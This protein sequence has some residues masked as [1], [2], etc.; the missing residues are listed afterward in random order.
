MSMTG[1]SY[2]ASG[3]KKVIPDIKSRIESARVAM[4]DGDLEKAYGLILNTPDF[5][6][7]D[8]GFLFG[9]TL[10]GVERVDA[11]IALFDFLK[12]YNDDIL[13][14]FDQ[15]QTTSNE[16]SGVLENKENAHFIYWNAGFNNA[17]DIVKICVNKWRETL[18]DRLVELSDDNLGDYVELHDFSMKWKESNM[19]HFSDYLR[20]MLLNRYGGFWIDA[21]TY[22]GQYYIRHME[23]VS[24]SVRFFSPKRKERTLANSYLYGSRDS[25]II[26]KM[27]STLIVYMREFGRHNAYF[28]FHYIFGVYVLTDEK[29]R[30]EFVSAPHFDARDYQTLWRRKNAK[31]SSGL[32][33]RALANHPLQ[34]LSYKFDVSDVLEGSVLDFLMREVV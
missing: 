18:E 20:L 10:S 11:H 25:Y 1:G 21:T 32:I 17:P 9:L 14:E 15:L 8:L 33:G 34:K 7:N 31:A 28:A 23:N 3:V 4:V 30:L 29:F 26:K 22:P 27:L 24:Q 12:M 19:A 2:S 6:N 13:F 5:F 16:L